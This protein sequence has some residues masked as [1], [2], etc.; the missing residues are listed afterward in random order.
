MWKGRCCKTSKKNK[1]QQCY[2]TTLWSEKWRR[3]R[4]KLELW[5]EEEKV[6]MGIMAAAL[7]HFQSLTT[8]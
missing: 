3:A 7:Y 1:Q 4:S 2:K 5:N 6:L 8:P